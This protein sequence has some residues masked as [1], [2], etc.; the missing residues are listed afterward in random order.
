MSVRSGAHLD[1][2]LP[3]LHT[4]HLGMDGL[5]VPGPPVLDTKKTDWPGDVASVVTCP[6]GTFDVVLLGG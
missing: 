2:D 4:C 6:C 5:E 3:F 1:G